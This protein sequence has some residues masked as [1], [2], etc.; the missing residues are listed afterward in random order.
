MSKHW[1]DQVLPAI[2]RRLKAEGYGG[3]LAF[4]DACYLN[5]MVNELISEN[6]R[7]IAALRSLVEASD[8]GQ[9]VQEW[10]SARGLVVKLIDQTSP[11]EE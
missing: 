10:E 6:R 3:T 5:T 8:P 4:S 7:L 2:R 9:Y 11:H 1:P